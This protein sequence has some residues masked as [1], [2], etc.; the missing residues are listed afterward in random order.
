MV[1]GS[2]ATRECGDNNIILPHA[3]DVVL[4][5][6]ID[7]WVVDAVVMRTLSEIIAVVLVVVG[8]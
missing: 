6:C 1:A 7:G 4:N 3:N 5:N 8:G 2:W